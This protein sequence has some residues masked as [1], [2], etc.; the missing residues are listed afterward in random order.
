VS[1]VQ[2][3]PPGVVEDVVCELP[4]V[5]VCVCVILLYSV[6]LGGQRSPLSTTGHV[7]FPSTQLN[8]NQSP[9]GHPGGQRKKLFV[10]RRRG[11]ARSGVL[12]G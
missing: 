12:P 11:R 10:T 8:Y 2:L 4:H 7:G 9:R 5:C 6:Q 3:G 1:A